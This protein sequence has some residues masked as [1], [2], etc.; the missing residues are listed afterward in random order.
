MR[1]EQ[2]TIVR[3]DW[4]TRTCLTA[5]TVLLTLLV[6][7]L[8]ADMSG[9]TTRARA[10]EFK[11]EKAKAAFYGGRWGTASASGKLA[12]V[13]GDTNK[14]MDELI[15]LFRRGDAKVRVVSLPEQS[16]GAGGTRNVVGNKK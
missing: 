7:G 16:T 5:I 1:N 2:G 8:W 13:Q 11:N 4:Y 3:V 10:A 14:K 6:V 9:P 12:A 15:R